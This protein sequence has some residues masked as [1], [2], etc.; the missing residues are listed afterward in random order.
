M[1]GVFETT[2]DVVPDDEWPRTLQLKLKGENNNAKR[3]TT[4]TRSYDARKAKQSHACSQL[5]A[6]TAHHARTLN[7]NLLHALHAYILARV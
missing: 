4:T 2:Y 3:G 5:L 7:G 1:S 6:H